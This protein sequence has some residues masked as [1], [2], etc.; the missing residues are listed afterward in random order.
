MEQR[1]NVAEHPLQPHVPRISRGFDL[2]ADVEV[3]RC[4]PAVSVTATE[5]FMPSPT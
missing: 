1:G 5:A 3:A 2:A 4:R